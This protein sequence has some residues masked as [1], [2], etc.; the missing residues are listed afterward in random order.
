MLV[1]CKGYPHNRGGLGKE[2]VS[3]LAL[4]E[5]DPINIVDNPSY[6]FQL[7]GIKSPRKLG[8]RGVLSL[9]RPRAEF[10][11]M[12]YYPPRERR[13]GAPCELVARGSPGQKQRLQP[14]ILRWACEKFYDP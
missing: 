1:L 9:P 8:D 5:G 11:L 3:L 10:M 4:L 14:Q 7:S 12:E 6:D 2:K 13:R